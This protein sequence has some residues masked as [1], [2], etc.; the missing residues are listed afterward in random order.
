MGPRALVRRKE[1]EQ[2]HLV[3]GG[4]GLTHGSPDL[5]ALHLLNSVLGRWHIESAVSRDPG[6]A[7]TGLLSLYLFGLLSRC[8][9][10]RRLCRHL[11]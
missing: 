6:A 8:G 9:Y 7:G 2:T 5:Y 1:T 10:I 3:V 11:P 4:D